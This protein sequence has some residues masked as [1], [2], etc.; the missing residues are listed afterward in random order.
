MLGFT[1]AQHL[2]D[3]AHTFYITIEDTLR[4]PVPKERNGAE[5]TA[6]GSH[7]AQNEAERIHNNLN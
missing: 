3:D 5:A 4:S 2:P 1:I 7:R 6:K